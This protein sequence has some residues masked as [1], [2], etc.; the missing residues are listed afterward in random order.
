MITFE[1][2]K[3]AYP[4]KKI[5]LSCDRTYYPND[6]VKLAEGAEVLLNTNLHITFLKA[7]VASEY[8]DMMLLHRIGESKLFHDDSISTIVI[9]SPQTEE[10]G[11]LDGFLAVTEGEKATTFTF[12]AG[13]I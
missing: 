12:L 4:G 5:I 13:G 10:K 3:A 7:D 11:K 2:I 6:V 8:F 9:A 1:E